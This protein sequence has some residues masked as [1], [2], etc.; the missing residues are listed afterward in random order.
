M[1]RAKEFLETVT[2]LTPYRLKIRMKKPWPDFLTIMAYDKLFDII[3]PE[4]VEKL[5]KDYGVKGIV[6]TG[7]FKF[8]EWV[9][10]T[11]AVLVKNENYWQKGLPYLDRLVWREIPEDSTRHLAFI[12]GEADALLG[13]PLKDVAQIKKKANVKI[14]QAGGGLVAGIWFNTTQRPF[15][16]KKVRQAL[17]LAI[18]R[19]KV[20]DSVYYSFGKPARG[21]FP[22]FFKEYYGS[23]DPYNV[24]KARRLLGEAGFPKST[25]LTFTLLYRA[26]RDYEA[27]ATIVQAMW[28]ELGVNAE[29]RPV[30]GEPLYQMMSGLNPEYKAAVSR[31]A[32]GPPITDYS[33]R[34]YSSQSNLNYAGYNKKGGASNPMIDKLLTEVAMEVNKQKAAELN[35]EI[36][37]TIFFEDVPAIII[38]FPDNVNAV[39]DYVKNWHVICLDYV[40]RTTVWISK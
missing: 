37:E 28:A 29:L 39:Y 34:M 9:K 20:V 38:G 1:G 8:L 27:I 2:V 21:I 36:S 3:N 18:D 40:P 15:T 10:G 22:A 30:A 19:K 11:R 5:G 12:S 14:Y 35:K 25:P 24:E 23:Q 7:P 13:T 16:D 6:G 32:F 33:Y 26:E 4:S 17:S 31:L